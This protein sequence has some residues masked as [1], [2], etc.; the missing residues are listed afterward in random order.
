MQLR[1]ALVKWVKPKMLQYFANSM[2]GR[3]PS[4]QAFPGSMSQGLFS[5]TQFKLNALPKKR[6]KTTNVNFGKSKILCALL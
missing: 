3:F 2:I 5:D 4:L 6:H 1:L